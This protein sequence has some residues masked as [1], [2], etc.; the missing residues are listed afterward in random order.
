M[1]F[2]ALTFATLAT[3]GLARQCTNL[4]IPLSLSARNGVFNLKAP[5]S[6][7]EVTNFMLDLT[8]QGHNLTNELLSGVSSSNFYETRKTT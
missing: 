4:T 8:R 6:D 1:L 5:A 2:L 7:I 3:T